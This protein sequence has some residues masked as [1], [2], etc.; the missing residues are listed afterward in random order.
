MSGYA[1][2][3]IRICTACGLTFTAHIQLAVNAENVIW[4]RYD[5]K[6]CPDCIKERDDD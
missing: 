3:V 2:T 4:W 6:H 5:P 1:F